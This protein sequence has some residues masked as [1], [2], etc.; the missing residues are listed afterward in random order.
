MIE[1][2]SFTRPN[3]TNFKDR[4]TFIFFKYYDLNSH[5]FL[6]TTLGDYFLISQS[7]ERFFSFQPMFLID[8]SWNDKYFL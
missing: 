2:K 8:L 1:L 4:F 3:E 7:F 5:C 6:W